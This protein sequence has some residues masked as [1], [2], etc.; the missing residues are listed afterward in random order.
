[1]SECVWEI[2]FYLDARGRNPVMEFVDGLPK[3]EQALVF[4]AVAL[5]RACGP[6]LGMPHARPVGAGLWELRAGAGRVFYFA[7][8]GH[9]LVLLH[10]YVKKSRRAPKREIEMALRRM[11]E[12]LE[13]Q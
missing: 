7:C 13:V 10:G 2:V 11:A 3:R 6:S 4:R 12:V 1:M 8:S 9:K 5:L